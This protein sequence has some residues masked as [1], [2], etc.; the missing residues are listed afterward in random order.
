M[1]LLAI[2]ILLSF[3]IFSAFGDE[4]SFKL[5]KC[6]VNQKF[7]HSNFSCFAKP[8]SRNF[9]TANVE[10]YLKNPV[11]EVFV[12]LNEFHIFY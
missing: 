4:A 2:S 11:Y 10:V 3:E 9:S 12:S 8:Y 7:V 1:K 6:D 5:I